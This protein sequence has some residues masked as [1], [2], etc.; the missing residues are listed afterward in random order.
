MQQTTLK[1]PQKALHPLYNPTQCLSQAFPRHEYP[2]GTLRG[3]FQ[4]HA[5]PFG[6]TPSR[7]WPEKA[8]ERP[9][10]ALRAFVGQGNN[11]LKFSPQKGQN[12]PKWVK[13]LSKLLKTQAKGVKT[14]S[15]GVKGG[16]TSIKVGP[17]A[18]KVLLT[19]FQWAQRP[20]TGSKSVKTAFNWLKIGQHAPVPLR[21]PYFGGFSGTSGFC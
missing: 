21:R 14:G 16:Q 7:G 17:K 6:A 19:G 10:K 11:C 5:V 20:S 15:N 2:S 12:R 4:S 18:P 13:M 1:P 3:T 9:K 8:L